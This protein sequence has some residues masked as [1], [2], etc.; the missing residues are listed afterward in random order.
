MRGFLEIVGASAWSDESTDPIQYPPAKK[1]FWRKTYYEPVLIK[2]DGPILEYKHLSTAQHYTVTTAF[3]L[4]A[5]CQFDQAGL[6]I[7]YDREHWIKAGI[8]VVTNSYS[9]W[10]T[11]QWPHYSNRETRVHVDTVEIR[12]H[13]RGTSFVVE[14][15]QNGEWVFIR[16]AHLNVKKDSTFGASVFACCPEDQQG[17]HAVFTHFEIIRGSHMEHNADGN[18]ENG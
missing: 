10:S 13:C 16:I 9:D 3:E 17:G 6:C 14:A 11:Q 8:E 15:K 2:D 18:D 7:R 5:V 1:D 12:I 4:T